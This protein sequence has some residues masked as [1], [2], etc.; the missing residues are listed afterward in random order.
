MH[1]FD[2]NKYLFFILSL[3]LI[4]CSS[5]SEKQP[6][7]YQIAIDKH[8]IQFKFT[9]SDETITVDANYDWAVENVSGSDWLE[10]TPM[11][12]KRDNKKIT[13]RCSENKKKTERIG[14]FEVKCG[15][16]SVKVTVSQSMTGEINIMSADTVLFHGETTYSFSVYATVP[17]NIEIKPN[18]EWI[19]A[20][21]S[22]NN[23]EIKLQ[24]YNN[25]AS[26]RVAQIILRG[27][28]ESYIADTLTL[29]QMNMYRYCWLIL[30][31]FYKC[32]DGANWN[33]NTGW[34][35]QRPFE[36]WYGLSADKDDLY[37]ITLRANNLSG[38]LPD[39]IC[40]LHSLTYCD[41]R[42]NALKGN[43][44]ADIGLLKNLITLV[45]TENK[46]SGT[47][48]QSL[49]NLQ[50]LTELSIGGNDLVA[51]LR[52]ICKNMSNIVVLNMENLKLNCEIPAE[53]SNLKNISILD[54][55]NCGLYGTLPQEIYQLTKVGLLNFYGNQLSGK[56][57]KEISNFSEMTIL[58][59]AECNFSGTIPPQLG[60]CSKLFD[61]HI[62]NCNFTGAMPQTVQKLAGWKS[63]S[64]MLGY[65]KQKKGELPLDK[66]LMGDLVY[67][68]GTPVAVVCSLT[69]K[70]YIRLS[71]DESVSDYALALSL[72]CTYV[73]WSTE[74]V[75]TGINSK[76]DGAK[77]TEDFNKYLSLNPSKKSLYPAFTW[78]SKIS[79]GIKWCMPAPND[80][81]QIHFNI[82]DI[83]S[84]IS[85]LRD[86]TTLYDHI[87]SSAESI[88]NSSG[89]E[90][91]YAYNVDPKGDVLYIGK[92]SEKFQV[93]G[94]V[95][96][97]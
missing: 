31:K 52:Q 14:N 91:C 90:S 73:P 39:E 95:Y 63:W 4:F 25:N 66:Y 40:K 7:V 78:C 68:G 44:P 19:S 67:D 71:N 11:S 79:N 54:L 22:D 28:K 46:L 15:D 36:E 62:T 10:I 76:D 41:L 93:R 84:T 92:K 97:K 48:P 81:L 29:T 64:S 18:S 12:G 8:Q 47:V 33:I 20:K 49:Y 35:S 43:I 51:D 60:F 21:K 77:N 30:E 85:L 94:V 45:L 50:N 23:I 55:P 32:T 6:L 57:S 34:L 3:F 86:K 59:I 87:V 17:Y 24:S 5:C 13:V 16:K 27:E 96:C 83:N 37:S 38:T 9:E 69:D 53:I 89:G 1:Y 2:R 65:F 88:D 61:L 82:A 72:D 80:L 74:N 26:E 56:L 75:T 70:K 42:Q 58:D